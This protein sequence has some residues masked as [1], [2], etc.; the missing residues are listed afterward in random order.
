MQGLLVG[1]G[2]AV[3]HLLRLAGTCGV[4]LLYAHEGKLDIVETLV[5]AT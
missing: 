5:S 3:A 4:G 2:E 1:A